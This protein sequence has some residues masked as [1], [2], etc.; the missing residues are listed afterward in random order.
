M[1]GENRQLV[2]A[3][4]Q[5]FRPSQHVKIVGMSLTSLQQ[6]IR[7]GRVEF[8]KRHDQRTLQLAVCRSL[9]K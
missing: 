8:G 7:V 6:V 4:L 5:I 3:K 1:I 9:R 2:M